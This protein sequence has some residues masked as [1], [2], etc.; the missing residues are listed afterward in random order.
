MRAGSCI[1]AEVRVA[2]CKSRA[3]RPLHD[4]QHGRAS[5]HSSSAACSGKPSSR[6]HVPLLLSPC[7]FHLP[8]S[9]FAFGSSRGR[10]CGERH[11]SGRYLSSVLSTV[12]EPVR[13]LCVFVCARQ[14]EGACERERVSW[15]L[16]DTRHVLVR[17]QRE[18]SK[19]GSSSGNKRRKR[20][21]R[22]CM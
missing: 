21:R 14:R 12:R 5:P 17:Q 18:D 11:S 22:V 9:E 19:R 3:P 8:V 15:L 13:G 6:M 1:H 7:V 16:V 20:G 10:S 2:S 4:L